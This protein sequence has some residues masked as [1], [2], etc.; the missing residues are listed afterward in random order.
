[1]LA[2]LLSL[3]GAS[4]AEP[5]RTLPTINELFR[6]PMYR[7]AIISPS[8]EYVAAEFFA[9]GRLKVVV[10]EI[11]RNIHKNVMTVEEYGDKAWI[12]QLLWADTNSLVITIDKEEHWSTQNRESVTYVVEVKPSDDDLERRFYEVEVR[13]RV[14]D[15][16]PAVDDEILYSPTSDL[17]SV[18]RVKLSDLPQYGED[19]DKNPSESTFTN[20]ALVARLDREVL[21]WI[22]DA[23]GQVRCA[24]A[25]SD[26]PV[27]VQIWYRPGVSSEWS[28]ALAQSDPKRFNEMIPLGI[29]EDGSKLLVATDRDRDRYGLFE[30]DPME[31]KLGDLLYEHPTAQIVDVTYDYSGSRLLGASYLES[32]VVRYAYLDSGGDPDQTLLRKAFPEKSVW[33]TGISKDQRRLSVLVSSPDSPGIFY[34]FDLDSEQSTE[35]GRVAPWLDDNVLA[36]VEA[37]KVQSSD[38]IEVEAFL[39]HPPRQKE[40]PPLVVMPHGGPVGVMDMRTFNPLVQY[41]ARSGFAVLQVNYRGS[42]GYGRAFRES[43]YRQWGR[44]IEDDIDA[45][46][47]YVMA[48]DSFATNRM[49]IVGASYGGYSALMSVIRHPTRYRCAATFAGVTDIALMFNS[50]DWASSGELREKMAEVTGDPELEYDEL[51]KYSPV[52]RAS[53][54]RVPIYLAH[55]IDDR[56]VDVD[57]AYRLKAMLD[58]H[59]APVLW[60]LMKDTGHG[61]PT[62]DDEIRYQVHLRRFLADHLQE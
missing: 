3:V 44:G 53:E 62:R 21:W 13:G 32:G 47:E 12:T 61:F 7:R 6:D 40:R 29:S 16:L 5:P 34:H 36:K 9:E 4:S 45:A 59:E 57:H 58:L 43:G 1:M 54:I 37:F 27:E 11:E 31:Q 17:T 26:D 55:G 38:G 14:I 35:I 41:L 10:V 2:C 51:R 46:V 25:M 28:I 42:G 30:Y 50:S 24:I 23:N 60:E 22:S 48:Q 33:T 49:C 18:Y 39:A 8:G 20:E 15:P 19:S 56:R 52:Y